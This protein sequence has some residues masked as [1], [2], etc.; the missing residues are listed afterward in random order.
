VGL[1]INSVSVRVIIGLLNTI[2]SNLISRA[3]ATKTKIRLCKMRL[4]KI[5]SDREKAKTA[6][7]NRP[8]K[9]I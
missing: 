8:R 2:A 9:V 3:I 1:K 4:E 6:R 5:G 7:T